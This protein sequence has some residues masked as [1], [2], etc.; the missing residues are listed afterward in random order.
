M[1]AEQQSLS[2]LPD[3]DDDGKATF[4]VALDKLPTTERLLDARVTIRLAESGGRAVERKITL[5]VTP[6]GRHDRR[7]AAV[8]RQVARRERQ[9]HLRRDSGRSRRQEDR[10]ARPALRT[11]EDRKRA[12]NGTGST[13]TGITSRSSPRAASPTASST[14]RRGDARAS[15]A[16]G[17]LGPLPAR[18]L[19]RRTVRSAHH[20]FV[21]CRF[22]C[23]SRR[24]HAGHAR[25]RAR[26]AG[27]P[28]GRHHECRRD[29]EERRP[30]DAECG[31][32]PHADA[33]S[34]PM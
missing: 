28:S 3:T 12:I 27:I 25:N 4:E 14:L 31:R 22:L 8:P 6:A 16:A 2:D 30:R 23:R 32:R 7:Q 26:Q 21:R 1:N 20:R 17:E 15:H 33:P 10:K 5:P 34:M 11:A 18:S 13:A 9:R 19:D 24:R 29:R